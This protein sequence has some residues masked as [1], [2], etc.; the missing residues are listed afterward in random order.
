ML[1]FKPAASR[2]LPAIA[3][4]LLPKV[5]DLFLRPA[6]DDEGYGFCKFEMRAGV[7][8]HKVLPLELKLCS[9]HRTFWSSRSFGA[10]LVISGNFLDPRILK[11]RDVKIHRLF[12]IVIE[13]QEWRKFLHMVSSPIRIRVSI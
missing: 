2:L 11:N 3:S 4:Q 13:P 8:G 10:C 1:V 6:V 9:H 12:S 7:D 5:V